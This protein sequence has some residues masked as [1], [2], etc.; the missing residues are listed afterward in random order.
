MIGHTSPIVRPVFLCQQSLER[1]G[2]LQGSVRAL[3]GLC[4]R[5]S[6]LQGKLHRTSRPSANRVRADAGG[7]VG[8]P[9]S[10]VLFSVK[11]VVVAPYI[12]EL[13]IQVNTG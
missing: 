4:A 11:L 10:A 2:F 6:V 13:C 5:V 1:N 3:S 9:Y 12:D 7:L 8:Q